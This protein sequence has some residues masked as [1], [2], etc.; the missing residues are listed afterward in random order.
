V[1]ATAR[2]SLWDSVWNLYWG[3]LW[4]TERDK[5][6]YEPWELQEWKPV[7]LLKPAI[8]QIMPVILQPP[9]TWYV[10]AYDPSHDSNA[11]Q[12]SKFM[13]GLWFD[14]GCDDAYGIAVK[15]QLVTGTGALRVRLNPTNQSGDLP[16]ASP[17]SRGSIDI[18][19]Q[20]PYQLYPDPNSKIFRDG[21]YLGIRSVLGES[22]IREMWS[23][24]SPEKMRALDPE[25]QGERRGQWYW[26]TQG[27]SA[28]DE[29]RYEIWETYHDYGRKLTIW[30]GDTILWNGKSPIPSGKFPVEL[31]IE[32]EGGSDTWG[33]GIIY[34]GGDMIQEA[35]NDVLWRINC[36]TRLGFAQQFV[37]YGPGG[38]SPRW[39]NTPG[40]MYDVPNPN[41]RIEPLIRPGISSE[42]FELAQLFMMLWN[43][44]TGVQDPMI[45]RP[46]GVQSGQAIMKLQAASMARP[47]KIAQDN[48]RALGRIGQI[49][50]EMMQ[51]YY[52]GTQTV[53]SMQSGGP[54]RHQIE[55]DQV[56]FTKE[57]QGQD[58]GDGELILREHRNPIPYRVLV[59]PQNS[60]PLDQASM[61][62]LMVQLAPILPNLPMPVQQMILSNLR[63]PGREEFFKQQQELALARVAAA[64]KAELEAGIQGQHNQG[65]AGSPSP[66]GPDS[67]PIDKAMALTAMMGARQQQM[68]PPADQGQPPPSGGP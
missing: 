43:Q 14:S 61:S 55:S 42:Y 21:R 31:L 32:D 7:N 12:L 29:Q 63:V 2:Q 4:P 5:S 50:L 53:F 49:A 37:K 60:R 25:L 56:L 8:A 19:Y 44:M 36:A 67:A 54:E 68:P 33:T 27:A 28:G 41:T 39:N 11:D 17:G 34:N 40:V 35:F 23:S 26:Q 24:V 30:S 6:S 15:D 10:S 9:A 1:E 13:Q 22:M 45:G 66:M 62:E 52:E 47:Q 51:A 64:R 38:M 18:A 16:T 57:F 20:D 65:V 58:N 3:H 48:T 59:Q 46:Q